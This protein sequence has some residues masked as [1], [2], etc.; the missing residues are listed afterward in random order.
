MKV[1]FGRLLLVLLVASL[2][3]CSSVIKP[4]N[5]PVDPSKPQF[6]GRLATQDKRDDYHVVLAFSGGGMRAAALSYGV[7]EALHDIQLS[8]SSGQSRTLLSEVDLIT[9]VSGGSF[10]SAYYGLYGDRIFTDFEQLFL[11]QDVKGSL[12]SRLLSPGYW[13]KSLFSGFD[14]TEMSVEYYDSNIFRGAT[15]G[16]LNPDGPF[17]E[18]NATDLASG[19]RFPF[20]PS[21]FDYICSDWAS[22]PV[23]RAVTASS[24]VPV[25]FPPVVLKNYAGECGYKFPVLEKQAKLVGESSEY[26]RYIYEAL[27][28]LSDAETWPYIH[29][30]DGG[31][32]DNL[33]LRSVIERVDMMG[34]ENIAQQNRLPSEIVIVLVNAETSPESGIEHSPR[35]PKLGT[36]VSAFSHVQVER[37]NLETRALFKRRLGHY[38]DVFKQHYQGEKPLHITYANL[39]FSGI[40]DD[41]VR[42]FFNNMPTTF[43]MSDAEVDSLIAAGRS[44][45]QAD[46]GFQAFLDRAGATLPDTPPARKQLC[47]NLFGLGC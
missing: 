39:G 30:V 23:A 21:V 18:I 25:L 38:R 27:E 47:R 37:Y 33:G 2:W 32:S 29:L 11:R 26:G 19:L 13:F 43:S 45:L 44:L 7:L 46:E 8:D 4:V 12:I 28:K 24:A 36:T 5:Q 42:R 3:G 14:R 40:A 34:A 1:D 9:S 17:I 15:L 35:K 31:I 20:T 22:F 10:T 6:N 41:E 16:D